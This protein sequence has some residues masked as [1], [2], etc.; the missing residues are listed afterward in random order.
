ML[1]TSEPFQ[2]NP[3]AIRLHQPTL[4]QEEI[5]IAEVS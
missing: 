1:K 2:S 5:W 3:V 4:T